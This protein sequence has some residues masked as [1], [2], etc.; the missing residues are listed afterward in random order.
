M[1]DL[2]PGPITVK[3]SAENQRLAIRRSWVL[4]IGE[5]EEMAIAVTAERRSRPSR[6]RSCV[7]TI[8][9]SSG[10]RS[11]TVEIRQWNASPRSSVARAKP[12]ASGVSG[13][14][15]PKRPITVSVFPTSIAS[16]IT[17]LL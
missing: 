2:V 8:A 6:S 14:S 3:S 1:P 17:V 11:A 4:A 9:C 7:K 15:G 12:M 13:A 16:S 10:V 5:D